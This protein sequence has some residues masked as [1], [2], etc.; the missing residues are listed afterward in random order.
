MKPG[1]CFSYPD[2]VSRKPGPPIEEFF[3]PAHEGV[4]APFCVDAKFAIAHLEIYDKGICTLSTDG[5][6]LTPSSLVPRKS[7]L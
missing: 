3:S 4:S 6:G 5:C 1:A 2:T 7:F